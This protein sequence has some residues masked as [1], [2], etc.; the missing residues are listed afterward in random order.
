MSFDEDLK[1]RI[2]SI[3]AQRLGK[4]LDAQITVESIEVVE[5]ESVINIVV[6]IETAEPP[7]ELAKRYFGL[8][9]RVRDE[10]GEDWRNYFPVILPSIGN[11]R[12]HA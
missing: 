1:S 10:L 6:R 3:I 2:N 9:G 12:V 8:T 4:N 11:T 7:K 5:S